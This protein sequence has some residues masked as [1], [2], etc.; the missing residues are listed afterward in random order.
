MCIRGFAVMI[1]GFAIS[2]YRLQLRGIDSEASARSNISFCSKVLTEKQAARTSEACT[3]EIAKC[4]IHCGFIIAAAL[5][6]QAHVEQRLEDV[7]VLLPMPLTKLAK[8]VTI[9]K[10]VI[11]KCKIMPLSP[12]HAQ[13]G[14]VQRLKSC[15]AVCSRPLGF[16]FNA[17]NEA[18]EAGYPSETCNC[19]MQHHA[20]LANPC[21]TRDCVQ[22]LKSFSTVC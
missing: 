12:I 9:V 17:F 2:N 11:R 15:A 22:R 5:G 8:L 19:E 21:S 20:F 10:N 14:C 16:S 13:H 18:S 4:C 1:F 6:V 3:Y 7:S